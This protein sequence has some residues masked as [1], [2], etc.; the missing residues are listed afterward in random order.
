MKP[1]QADKAVEFFRTGVNCSM[2]VLAPFAPD[3]G[4]DEKTALRIAAPFGGGMG[5]MGEACGA[6]TGAFM[7]LGLAFK[8]KPD[9]TVE[10]RKNR[11][12]GMVRE[13]ARQYSERQGGIRCRDILGFDLSTPEGRRLFRERNMHSTKCA[14]CVRAAAEL[15][16][17]I[18]RKG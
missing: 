5:R 11:L 1:S 18:I 10:E 3:Y 15:V 14:E 2:A 17:G 13:L 7:V 12:Y 16:E 8:P 6:V 9:E 4:L